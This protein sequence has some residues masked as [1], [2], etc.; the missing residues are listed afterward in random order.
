MATVHECNL[1]LECQLCETRCSTFVSMQRHNL[2]DHPNSKRSFCEKCMEIF[3][4]RDKLKSHAASNHGQN[5]KIDCEMCQDS[6]HCKTTLEEHHQKVHDYQQR[7]FQCDQC[8][9]AYKR[10][11]W[12]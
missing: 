1:D 4:S 2:M 6:F 8:E 9:K 11:Y 10:F 3:S 7:N 5:L 12:A